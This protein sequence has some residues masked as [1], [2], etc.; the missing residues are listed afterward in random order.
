MQSSCLDKDKEQQKRWALASERSPSDQSSR[1]HLASSDYF[2]ICPNLANSAAQEEEVTYSVDK[3][4]SAYNTRGAKLGEGEEETGP[5][6]GFP[7]VQRRRRTRRS[8]VAPL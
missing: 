5:T 1:M 8:Q 2:L 7:A 3:H 4:P 6:L